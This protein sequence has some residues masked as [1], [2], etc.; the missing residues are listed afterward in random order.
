[1]LNYLDV[2]R[3]EITKI[4]DLAYLTNLETLIMKRNKLSK[5]DSI[6]NLPLIP[7]LR[8]L[9]ISLNK[10]DCPPEGVLEILSRCKS[11]RA[12]T[13][14]KNPIAKM[15]NYRKMV[16]SR[17]RK[18][19]SLDGKQVCKEERRRCNVWGKVVMNG[20]SYEE[21]NEA[22]RQ[23]LLK[24]RSEQS[25]ANAL[26]R[27]WHGSIHGSDDGSTGGKLRKV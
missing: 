14:M 5:A 19:T 23:E 18:L 7:K 16:I 21:A 8:E 11:L 12:L 9:D 17:C 3:N 26:R 10:I 20:G 4:D 24:I 27:S 25:S 2:S 13:M 1:M 22:D 6:E 15:P